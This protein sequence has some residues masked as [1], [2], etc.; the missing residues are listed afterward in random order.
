MGTDGVGLGGGEKHGAQVVMAALHEVDLTGLLFF[1]G[2]LFSVSALDSAGV[3]R[4][5][6][7]FLLRTFGSSPV[8]LCTLLGVSSAVVDNVPLVDASLDMFEEV[9]TDD[10]LWLL[11]A[12][13]AGTGGS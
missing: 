9:P 6:A 5:Y 8:S 1:T 2:V 10:A 7:H 12:L 4:E 3:L 11:I 13:A